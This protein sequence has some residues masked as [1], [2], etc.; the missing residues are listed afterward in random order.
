MLNVLGT[1]FSCHGS[2]SCWQRRRE[3]VVMPRMTR[4]LSDSGFYHV[5]L[6]GN[7]KQLLFEDDADRRQFLQ[8]LREKTDTDGIAVIAWCLM[9]NHVHL[10]L[11]DTKD[12]LSHMMHALAT[13]YARRFNEKTGHVGAVFQ[14]RFFS[15]PIKC[16]RQLLQAV[17]YLHENP[18]KAGIAR[19]AD[20][21]WSSYREYVHGRG[22]AD[23]SLVLDMVGGKDGFLRMSENARYGSY[24]FKTTKLVPDDEAAEA[25]RLLLGGADPATLKACSRLYR[26]EALR[27]LR[28]AGMTVKQIERLTGIGHSTISRATSRWMGE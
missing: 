16:D 25:A 22:I 17:R 4:L 27:T 12:T 14:G 19:A 24:Y 15:A 7:G 9:S 21:P 8:L 2:P 20:Y 23:T 28:R 5:V 3:G 1:L 10:L 18:V 13:A 11:E 6:R 26:D